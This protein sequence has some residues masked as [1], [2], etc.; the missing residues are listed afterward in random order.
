MNGF[1]FMPR[2]SE[3]A[4]RMLI[5]IE[6]N[7]YKEKDAYQV[8]AFAG[9]YLLAQLIKSTSK[10]HF[11]RLWQSHVY[12]CYNAPFIGSNPLFEHTIDSSASSWRIMQYFG[13]LNGMEPKWDAFPNQ[14]RPRFVNVLRDFVTLHGLQKELLELAARRPQYFERKGFYNLV[15][16]CEAVA[17]E[18]SSG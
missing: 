1:I 15:A 11:V 5:Q 12:K 9:P 14:L 16:D 6:R 2:G 18:P 13:I 7:I 4:R 3:L 8:V 17:Q 10:E